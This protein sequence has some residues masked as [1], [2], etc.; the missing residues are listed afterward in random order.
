MVATLLATLKMSLR[1][2][3]GVFWMFAF[4]LILPTLMYGVFGGIA[5]SY[6]F[7]PQPVAVVTDEAWRADAGAQ[8]LVDALAGT[9]SAGA[10]TTGASTTD[11]GDASATVLVTPQ[12]VATQA[13][14]HALLREGRVVA[15]IG[16]DTHGRLAMSTSDTVA[17]AAAAGTVN[18]GDPLSLTLSVLNTLITQYNTSG[19]LVADLIGDDPSLLADP[20]ALQRLADTASGGAADLS[21]TR[22]VSL[23]HAEPDDMARYFFALLGMVAL[24]DATFA[25]GALC[26]TQANLSQVGM[27][28]SVG[29]LRKSTTVTAVFLAAWLVSFLSLACSFLYLRYVLG[30]GVGGREPLAFVA[31]LIA[32]FTASAIGLALGAVP[33]LSEGVKTGIAVGAAIG[34]SALAG[35]QGGYAMYLSDLIQR[36]LPALHLVNPAKQIADLFYD[37]LYY[38]D[39]APFAATASVL[40]VMAA[41][42][43]A[44]AVA[45]LR[46]QRHAHL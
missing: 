43:L 25:I 13:E 12:P 23:T 29:P 19:A 36:E 33:N 14:A 39:L 9:T 42:A 8:R 22:E 16:I 40:V 10:S 2:G 26:R 6:R 3:S 4:P 24:M 38:D 28:V 46:R 15:S 1:E 27:R 32:S 31:I 37:I 30:V 17:A 11:A 20:N 41:I 34:M 35:L 5:D 7:E 18:G 44:L 21:F 45:L